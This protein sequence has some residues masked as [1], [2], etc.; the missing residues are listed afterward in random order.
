MCTH[1]R[2]HP[3]H[4]ES[5]HICHFQRFP[6]VPSDPF[7][8]PCSP[9]PWLL[10]EPLI[11]FLALSIGLHFWFYINENI[12][13]ALFIGCSLLLNIIMGSVHVSVCMNKFICFVLSGISIIWQY[14]TLLSSSSVSGHLGYFQV[15]HL[16]PCLLSFLSYFLSFYLSIMHFYLLSQMGTLPGMR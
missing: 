5:G 7:L 1:A 12:Q 16:L 4:Q 9:H 6:P 8:P 13:L 10:R 3:R 11:C 14:L 2:S 15:S